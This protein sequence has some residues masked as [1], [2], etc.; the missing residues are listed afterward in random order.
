MYLIKLIN[1]LITGWTCAFVDTILELD[2]FI[3]HLTASRAELA[4]LLKFYKQIQFLK[5]NM[6]NTNIYQNK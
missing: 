4:G 2:R 5:K 3:L 6:E 1:F